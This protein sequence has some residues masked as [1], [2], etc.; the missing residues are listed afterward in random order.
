[1]IRSIIIDD[2]DH[3]LD[4]LN[5]LLTVS[6]PDDILMMDA[7]KNVEAAIDGVKRLRP[8][9][10]FLDIQIGEKTGFEFLAAFY[11]IPFDVIFTTAYDNF[12]VQ[13]FRCSAVDYLLKPVDRDELAQAIGKV[14]HKRKT[15]D[16]AKR[17]QT[18]L[19]N[20]QA[21][22]KRMVLADKNGYRY[23]DTG[24][25]VRI[26]A[27]ANYAI[28]HYT[29][30][31]EELVP[32]TLKEFDE[33]LSLAGFFRVHQSHLVNTKYILSYK[34]GKTGTLTVYGQQEI[35]VSDAHKDRLMEYLRG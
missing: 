26:E 34:R 5:H 6:H 15:E 10:V 3:C 16:N 30:Q 7:F 33:M 32:K 13:A 25:I 19:H 9:L 29:D 35:P 17:V 12:A 8:E 24:R 18:L 2:E 27:R 21:S 23:I 31:E 4:R 28:I 1:M 22:N 11:T 20:V 14:Q